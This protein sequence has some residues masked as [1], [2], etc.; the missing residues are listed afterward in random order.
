MARLCHEEL[1]L[2]F[3]PKQEAGGARCQLAFLAHLLRDQPCAEGATC[4][5]WP[6]ESTG[7]AVLE[8]WTPLCT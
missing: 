8:L 3:C 1:S 7:S 4:V 5:H 2:T 6:I